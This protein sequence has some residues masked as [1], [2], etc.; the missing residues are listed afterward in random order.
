[1]PTDGYAPPSTR[2][3]W[4]LPDPGLVD[5]VERLHASPHIG[6]SD[7]QAVACFTDDLGRSMRATYNDVEIS[8]GVI[9]LQNTDGGYLVGHL[10]YDCEVES[11]RFTPAD[12]EAPTASRK[13]H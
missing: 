2:H 9:E 6:N 5:T 4:C 12:P 8:I 7:F 3:S 1:M 10:T 13:K 11:F